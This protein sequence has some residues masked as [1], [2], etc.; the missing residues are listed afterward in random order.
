MQQT[1]YGF[2]IPIGTALSVAREIAAGRASSTIVVG[3][4]PFIG[5]YVGQGTDSNPQDQAA[6]QQQ[7]NNGFGGFGN[8][9][10]NGERERR[11]SG[12]LQQRRQ[13]VGPVHDRLGEL[14]PNLGHRHDLAI[15]SPTV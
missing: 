4:P 9:F 13:P 10:G 7:Q 6:Q 1:V 15:R 14:G 12:L 5:I 11:Q 3:Y 8:G 2:A